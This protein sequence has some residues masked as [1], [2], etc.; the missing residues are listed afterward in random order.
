MRVDLLGGVSRRFPPLNFAWLEGGLAWAYVLY[1]NIVGFWEKRGPQAIQDL[2]PN[3]VDREMLFDLIKQHGDERLLANLDAIQAQYERDFPRPPVVDEFAACK[4]EQASDVVDL[5][6]KRFYFGSE[7][8]DATYPGAFRSDTLPFGATLKAIY[9]SDVGHFDVP[10]MSRVLEEAYEAVERGAAS[11]EEFRKFT[12][13][14]PALLHAEMNP[15]FF[16][17]T[18]VEKAVDELLAKQ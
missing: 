9:G 10:D 14:N 12:F 7:G 17:G 5:F 13:E 4:M 1:D 8:D 11:P 2:D 6:T 15:D 18:R 16:K 3:T